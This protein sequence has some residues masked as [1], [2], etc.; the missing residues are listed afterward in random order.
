[1]TI[2]HFDHVVLTVQDIKA[3]CDFYQK[4]LGLDSVH[5]GTG[6]TALQFGQQ[7]LNLY[8]VGKE[9]DPKR[10]IPLQAQPTSVF[11]PPCLLSESSPTYKLARFLLWK[12]R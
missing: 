6:R 1:M 8:V 5:F 11:S 10:S 7:K 9:F 12:V 3:T 4:V 2:D